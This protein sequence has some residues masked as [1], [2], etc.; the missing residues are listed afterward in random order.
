MIREHRVVGAYHNLKKGAPGTLGSGAPRCRWLKPLVAAIVVPAIALAAALCPPPMPAEQI[1][2]VV[3]GDDAPDPVV[4]TESVAVTET[5]V[6]APAL[7]DFLIAAAVRLSLCLIALL[8]LLRFA[9]WLQVVLRW[10]AGATSA[11]LIVVLAALVLVRA[12]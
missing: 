4:P 7:T 10:L 9:S 3:R 11:S 6:A 8:V 5:V 2:T 1:R 12:G